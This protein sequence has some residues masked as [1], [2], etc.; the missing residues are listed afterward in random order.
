MQYVQVVQSP[1]GMQAATAV[2]QFAGVPSVQQPMVTTNMQV[3][4]LQ[5]QLQLQQL[6]QQGWKMQMPQ[7][8]MAG[9]QQVVPHNGMQMA[10]VL[11]SP[12]VP[13]QQAYAQQGYQVVMAQQPTY[14]QPTE[15]VLV[16][17]PQPQQQPQQQA[18]TY[19]SGVMPYAMSLNAS[20]QPQLCAQAAET[21]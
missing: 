14:P 1:G 7:V 11:R 4:Q 13:Q 10:Y 21:A 17:Q 8:Q 2:P 6:Q 5:Q 16:Q 3:Q 9:T 20:Q 15:Y 19:V 18:G 12:Q